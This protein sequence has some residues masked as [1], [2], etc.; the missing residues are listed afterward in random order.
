MACVICGQLQQT[1]G[2]ADALEKALLRK[3]MHPVQFVKS[4]QHLTCEARRQ[5]HPTP[6]YLM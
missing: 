1:H 6:A 3:C 2:M 5:R 4:I